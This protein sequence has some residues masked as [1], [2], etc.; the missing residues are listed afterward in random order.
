MKKQIEILFI[1][2]D[3]KD[4]FNCYQATG[5]MPAISRRTVKVNI[6]ADLIGLADCEVIESISQVLTIHQPKEK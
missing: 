5:H 2:N 1:I 6:D 3:S 4:A